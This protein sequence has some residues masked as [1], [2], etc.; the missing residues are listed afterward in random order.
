MQNL[1]DFSAKIPLVRKL[2]EI[3]SEAFGGSCKITKDWQDLGTFSGIKYF[4]SSK[5][6]H[7]IYAR[8]IT[9]NT[10]ERE[11]ISSYFNKEGLLEKFLVYDRNTKSIRSFDGNGKLLTN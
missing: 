2:K 7:H 9:A 1:N 8:Q 11:H 3:I 5:T 10:F 6:Q 4:F